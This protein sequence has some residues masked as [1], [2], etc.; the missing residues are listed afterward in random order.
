MAILDIEKIVNGTPTKRINN[1][2]KKMSSN[3]TKESAQEYYDIY[4][5]EP[6][7]SF[8]LENSRIIFSEPYYGA[9]YYESIITGDTCCFSS[10]NNEYDKVASFLEENG[11]NMS[12][13]QFNKYKSLSL[14]L[15]SLMERTKNTRMYAEFIKEH[16]DENFENGLSEALFT[17]EKCNDDTAIYEIMESIYDPVIFFTYAPYVADKI[18]SSSFKNLVNYYCKEASVP[19]E[20]DVD[21]WASFVETAICCNKLSQD[22]A[23]VESVNKITNRGVRSVFEYFMNVSLDSKLKEFSEE[24]VN[25][26]FV[27]YSDKSLAIN[28]VMSSWYEAYVDKD[29]NLE[30]RNQIN[31]YKNIVYESTLEIMLLEYQSANNTNDLAKGYSLLTTEMSLEDAFNNVNTLFTESNALFTEDDDVSDDDIEDMDRLANSNDDLYDKADGGTISGKKPQPPKPSNL[32]NS[33]QFKAMDK[34]AKQQRKMADRGKKSDDIKGAVKATTAI[35]SNVINSI[36]DQVRS[37]DDA[38]SERRKKYMVEPGFRKKAFRN[39]KLAL[40]YGSAA[41]AKLSFVPVVALCRHWSKQK[42]RRIRNELIREINTEIKV[43]EEK[44]NDASAR[45]DREEKYRL[46]RIKDKLD[47]ELVRV[48]T[49]SK[50]V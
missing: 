20:Y 29:E 12:E 50:Y 4:S 22:L 48:K 40:L 42:D 38:D 9:D 7:L 17:Y 21:K 8:L 49:N 19:N 31:I 25:E 44:I 3:Y 24:V 43:C 41:Q 2:Y 27:H 13:S 1:G 26:S 18:D 33:I 35:P 30:R 6:H 46:I 10:L 28:N 11:P 34:E 39:M 32:A 14:V 45:D 37:I 5:K 15:E 36:K 47:A 16:K 23:Y